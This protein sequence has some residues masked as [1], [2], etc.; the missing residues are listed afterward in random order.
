MG[1]NM[2]KLCFL[3]LF[4]YVNLTAFGQI[5]ESSTSQPEYLSSRAWYV[6]R[7]WNAGPL[8]LGLTQQL[9]KAVESS[10]RNDFVWAGT[11][12][13]GTL[14]LNMAVEGDVTGE[15]FIGL[16]EEPDWSSEPVQV[17]S[18]QGPGE[19][20]IENLPVGKFQIGA[21]IG[22]LPAAAAL[23]VQQTWPGP[24]EIERG[25]TNSV[26]VLVSRE[27]Q[28]HTSGWYNEI[29]SRDFIEDQKEIDT[30]TFLT[31]R[32]T[33]PGGQPVAF[34]TV[35]VREYNPGAGSIRAPNRGTNEN[36]YY[37]CDGIDWPYRGYQI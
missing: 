12:K 11:E 27:F 1:I 24:V 3:I 28:L 13:G 34:A 16:F 21:M 32:V 23:G 6:L 29:V 37:K 15:I 31:G 33:G 5:T 8:L 4:L 26:K 17:R 18:F 9:G 19:Y 25:K 22:S 7:Q 14:K 30:D 10:Q 20:V 35:Q 2:K 36:G